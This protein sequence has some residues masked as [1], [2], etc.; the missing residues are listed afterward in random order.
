MFKDWS[1][2]AGVNAGH[3]EQRVLCCT[4]NR[5]HKGKFTGSLTLTS[6]ILRGTMK[7]NKQAVKQKN[8][9]TARNGRFN[10]D[11]YEVMHMEKSIQAKI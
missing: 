3:L 6:R 8:W 10:T 2:L 5:Q 1:A 4:D 7:S 11:E 9:M